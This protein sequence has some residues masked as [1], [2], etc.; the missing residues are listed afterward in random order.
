[1]SKFSTIVRMRFAA[2]FTALFAVVTGGSKGVACCIR[3][4]LPVCT[5]CLTLCRSS[6]G[7]SS[8]PTG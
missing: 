2:R 1:M 3:A 7:V 5:A 4:L 6:E 8:A